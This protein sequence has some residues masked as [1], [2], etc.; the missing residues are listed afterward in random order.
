MV[1]DESLVVRNTN[2]DTA[3]EPLPVLACGGTEIAHESVNSRRVLD[4]KLVGLVDCVTDMS[5]SVEACTRLESTT[6]TDCVKPTEVPNPK[7]VVTLVCM[8][9][10]V[11]SVAS[12][13]GLVVSADKIIELGKV[14]GVPISDNELV[15]CVWT[16][17]LDTST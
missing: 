15:L 11:I 2:P 5:P 10:E 9:L 1:L 3:A 13:E 6:A 7:L 16:C 14:L 17:W 4:N 8:E 12:E